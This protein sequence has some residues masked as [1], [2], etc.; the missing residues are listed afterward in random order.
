MKNRFVDTSTAV[1]IDR[2]VAK[3]LRDL[4]YSSGKVELK[5]VRDLL[6]LDLQYYTSS[7]DGLLRDVVHKL[8]IGA[9]QVIKRPLLLLEA[10]KKFDLKALFVP[11]RKRILIASD[12]PVLKQRWSEGH[13]I[14]HSLCTWHSE[15]LLGDNKATL[16]PMCHEIIESEA[17]YG[18]GRLL[19]PAPQFL[20]LSRA[21]AGS[22]EHI[23]ALAT[24]FGNTITSTL[25]RYVE[26]SES[27]AIGLIGEHPHHCREGEPQIAYFIRS[28][29]FANEFK[30]VGEEALFVHL[31]KYCRYNKGGPLG[32]SVVVLIDDNKVE[33]E[34]EFESFSTTYHTLTLAV[35][36]RKKVISAKIPARALEG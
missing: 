14:S 34:F 10:I 27:I 32:K 3:V 26:N 20:E 7:D 8:R 28:P 15:Y 33:H 6:R 13:E 21:K 17:N 24:Q 16:S 4:D 31:R 5:E 18:T 1:D 19:F 11:D 9:K 30:G 12:L 29:K 25:W 23:R 2:R 35:H 36:L 22:L